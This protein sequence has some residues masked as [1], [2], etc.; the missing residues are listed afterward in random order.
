MV[1][2][3]SPPLIRSDEN[4]GLTP[5]VL[6]TCRNLKEAVGK[7]DRFLMETDYIDDPKRPGAVLSLRTIPRYTKR[8]LDENLVDEDTLYKI[9]KE[10]PEKIYGIEIN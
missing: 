4:H 8:L 6:S 7:G 5:S 3:F 10:L 9:H 1:K 2:H